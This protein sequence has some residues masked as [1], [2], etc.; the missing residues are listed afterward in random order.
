MGWKGDQVPRTDPGG[1]Q[2]YGAK[3]KY[4]L[5]TT[6]ISGGPTSLG[7]GSGKGTS[8]TISSFQ[9]KGN[10]ASP[11]VSNDN[12]SLDLSVGKERQEEPQSAKPVITVAGLEF[13]A[14]SALARVSI[15]NTAFV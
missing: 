7:C 4:P 14:I 13:H 11:G 5:N 12:V 15:G 6:A 2:D 9:P 3:F 8:L 1:G 10:K